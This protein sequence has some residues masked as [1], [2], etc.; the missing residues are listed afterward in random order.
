MDRVP[1]D[2]I[3]AFDEAYF[4]YVDDP[5]FPDSLEYVRTG[6]PVLVL[7]TFSKIYSL[8]GLRIGY[9]VAP[10]ELIHYLK[11][12]REPFNVTGLAHICTMSLTA[13]VFPI[14]AAMRTSFSSISEWMFGLHSRHC[15]SEE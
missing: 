15:L 10:E 4:E 5:Q 9:G 13:W 3:V 12:V 6:R 7:R 14:S 8:A 1:E 2:V 11:L